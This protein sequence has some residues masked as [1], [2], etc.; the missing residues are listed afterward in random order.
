MRP[1]G[2]EPVSLERR[3]ILSLLSLPISPRPHG[4]PGIVVAP[5]SGCKR[6]AAAGAGG[7]RKRAR[8]AKK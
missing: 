4:K 6:V 5:L 1:T 8:R 3:Q 7:G 2:L